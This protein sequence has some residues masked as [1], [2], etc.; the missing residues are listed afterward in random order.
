MAHC[1]RVRQEHRP[2]QA[3]DG[4]IAVRQ[5]TRSS[6]DSVVRSLGEST[7]WRSMRPRDLAMGPCAIL[8]ASIARAFTSPFGKTRV[9]L[10][11]KPHPRVPA[12]IM[13]CS[14]NEGLDY[15]IDCSLLSAA[16]PETRGYTQSHPPSETLAAVGH[17]PM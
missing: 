8:T 10:Q 5:R 1:E 17:R 16:P 14:T 12:R 4:P 9:K 15:S 11:R 3:I 2:S 13:S 7:C 6:R